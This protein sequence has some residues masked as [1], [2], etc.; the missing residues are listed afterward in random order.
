MAKTPALSLTG[1]PEKAPA[2]GH[3]SSAP[4]P[5]TLIFIVSGHCSGICPRL[6][7]LP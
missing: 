2:I 4:G 7:L 1:V 6:R 3:F 5:A